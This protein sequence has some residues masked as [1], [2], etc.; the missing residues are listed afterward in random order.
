MLGQKFFFAVF[1]IEKCFL[2]RYT[3]NMAE[4]TKEKAV[5]GVHNHSTKSDGVLS[6][7]QLIKGAIQE[8]LSLFA[9]SDHHTVTTYSGEMQDRAKKANMV[10]LNGTEISTKEKRRLHILGHF[11]NGPPEK[12]HEINAKMFS[13]VHNQEMENVKLVIFLEQEFGIVL[14]N[15]GKLLS[16]SFLSKKFIASQIVEAGYA[17]TANEA[18]A[19]F[20]DPFATGQDFKPAGKETVKLVT[21]LD[22]MASIAH[23][24]SAQVRHKRKG[25]SRLTHSECEELIEEYKG[26]GVKGI[27]IPGAHFKN[28]ETIDRIWSYAENFNLIP[29]PGTDFHG[30]REGITERLGNPNV[31][32]KDV[33]RFLA[34]V[35]LASPG[36][37]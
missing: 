18:R 36:A 10:L 22:G 17:S 32:K 27:E 31:K 14:G 25:G 2:L 7:S 34:E 13:I 28:Q 4:E 3:V 6:P 5:A 26:Y 19:K 9:I 12:Y 16:E 11:K 37:R 23:I 21:D 24:W 20:I 1:P 29:V 30:N 15:L 33:D 8:E 35:E